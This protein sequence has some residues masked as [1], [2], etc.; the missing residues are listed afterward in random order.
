MRAAARA[1][2]AA[3]SP[4]ARPGGM[5]DLL[6]RPPP[7]SSALP[8]GAGPAEVERLPSP[9]RRGLADLVGHRA[10]EWIPPPRPPPRTH[11]R[12]PARP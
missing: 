3:R 6:T 11:C 10:A 2:A 5:F 1:E 7:S 8:D 4:R 9:R 12:S